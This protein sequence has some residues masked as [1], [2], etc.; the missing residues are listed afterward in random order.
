MGSTLAVNDLFDFFSNHSHVCGINSMKRIHICMMGESFPRMWDQLAQ[1]GANA[2]SG[3]IIPTYVGSTFGTIVLYAFLPESFPRMWD[4]L[5]ECS[6]PCCSG[7]IIPTYVG[8]TLRHTSAVP[9]CP[10]HSHVCGINCFI[11]SSLL[12]PYESFP[13]MWDQ[14]INSLD[15]ARKT[16]IIP[17]YVGSTHSGMVR[18]L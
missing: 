17:T 7:R 1:A 2:A 12:M 16:R 9:D 14:L 18:T 15:D 10:N 5:R 11:A 13:R 4:Q 3:R 6:A 8:S